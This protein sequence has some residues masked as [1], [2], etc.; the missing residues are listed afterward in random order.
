MGF[1]SGLKGLMNIWKLVQQATHVYYQSFNQSMFMQYFGTTRQYVKRIV[2]MPRCISCSV[3][4]TTR[5]T[6]FS[7]KWLYIFC[8]VQN[9]DQMKII[10]ILWVLSSSGMLGSVE[11]EL[12]FLNSNIRHVLYVVCFLLGY[13]PAS[14]FYMPKFRNTLSVPSS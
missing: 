10:L 3:S 8:R 4:K 12:V 7:G 9:V 13:S 14:E 2:D 11:L 5:E 1:N 6:D